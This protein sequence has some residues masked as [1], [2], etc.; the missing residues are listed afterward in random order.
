MLDM[1]HLARSVFYLLVNLGPSL[2]AT[3]VQPLITVAMLLFLYAGWHVRDEG[4]ITN[5]LEV[6]FV[7][8]R[9]YRAEHLR[10]LESA[11]MQT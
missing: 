4:G 11:L 1:L 2:C 3:F 7:N 5:G 8:T 9:A 6:A 10:D